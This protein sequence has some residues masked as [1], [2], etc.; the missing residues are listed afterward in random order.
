MIEDFLR[1][2]E[3]ELKVRGRAR[4]RVVSECR[5][6]LE[7]L[8]ADH[9]PEAAVGAFGDPRPLARMLDVEIA[10]SRAIRAT[11]MTA[12][13]VATTAVSTLALIHSADSGASA[14]PVWAVAFFAAAQVAATVTAIA[15]LH[16]ARIRRSPASAADTALLARRNRYALIAAG[17]TMFCAGGALT[18]NASAAILLAGPALWLAAMLAVT[19]SSILSSRLTTRGVKAD[20]SPYSDLGELLHIQVPTIGPL[21]LAL[22]A[23]VGAMVRDSGEAGETLS[24]VLVVGAI[25]AGLVLAAYLAMRRPLG[26]R[27][28]RGSNIA[29]A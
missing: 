9:G 1:E 10:A 13:A 22:L 5:A 12:A 19:R 16:A 15:L 7:D 17:F 25:E 23:A 24:K 4:R 14:P 6:H 8:V 2:F 3:S 27:Q 21:A 11:W 28:L 20:R 26:L 18:G 29:G